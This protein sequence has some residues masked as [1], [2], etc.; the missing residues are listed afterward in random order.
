ML[1]LWLI[2]PFGGGNQHLH[3]LSHILLIFFMSTIFL[4]LLEYIVSCFMCHS[5]V[6]CMLCTSA[7]DF[8]PG[9]IVLEDNQHRGKRPRLRWDI[10]R[11]GVQRAP[12][13]LLRSPDRRWRKSPI[14]RW[15]M[16]SELESLAM[17]DDGKWIGDYSTTQW[18][19]RAGAQEEKSF[20]ESSATR[21]LTHQLDL[22]W[23]RQSVSS[24]DRELQVEAWNYQTSKSTEEPFFGAAL[25]SCTTKSCTTIVPFLNN[26]QY[27]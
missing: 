3:I 4:C 24:I 27:P 8:A 20:I 7:C 16:V 17:S 11:K 26:T 25:Q 12:L 14:Q 15:P 5:M 6:Y 19:R 22:E 23:N 10:D 2:F 18:I 1:K 21:K 9:A 13:T